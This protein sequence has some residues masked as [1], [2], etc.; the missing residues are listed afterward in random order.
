MHFAK[1]FSA[2]VARSFA[3]VCQ[4]PMLTRLVMTRVLVPIA[5]GTEKKRTV[6][7]PGMHDVDFVIREKTAKAE[8]LPERVRTVHAR[9]RKYTPAAAL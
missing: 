2:R 5:A 3:G 6:D 1:R 4:Y 8:H 9:K 7:H